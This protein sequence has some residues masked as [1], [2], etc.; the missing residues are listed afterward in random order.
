[1][2]EPSRNGGRTA[3]KRNVFR[4]WTEEKL[5]NPD[6]DQFGHVNNAVMASFFEAGRMELFGGRPDDPGAAKLQLVVVRLLMNFHKELYYPGRVAIGSA[7]ARVGRSSFDVVQGLFTGDDCI[8]SAEATCVAFDP[9]RRR[10]TEIPET[11]RQYLT[12]ADARSA[13]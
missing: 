11:M 3:P 9:D 8:A 7:V 6:T 10:S 5:R 4:F 12:Q 1:M 13:S 2:G